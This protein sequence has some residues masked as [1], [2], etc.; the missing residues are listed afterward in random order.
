MLKPKNVNIIG[1]RKGVDCGMDTCKIHLDYLHYWVDGMNDL[2]SWQTKIRYSSGVRLLSGEGSAR[3]GGRNCHL[4]RVYAWT[5]FIPILINLLFSGV[6]F[7]NDWRSGFSSKYEVPF[8]LLLL[9]PQWRT[10]KI[11]MRYFTHKEEKELANQLD[12]N[13]KEVSFIEPFCESGMQVRLLLSIMIFANR[14]TT[15]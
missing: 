9:Y 10:L 6:I 14:P 15:K 3:V 2:Q 1:Y 8:L 4:L 12:E 11:L 13:D 7:Y 5:M